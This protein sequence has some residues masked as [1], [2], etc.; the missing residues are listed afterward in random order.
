MFARIFHKTAD[1]SNRCKPNLGAHCPK[2]DRKTDHE[3]DCLQTTKFVMLSDQIYEG[4]LPS[5]CD[6][7]AIPPLPSPR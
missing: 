3:L 7:F 6:H 1:I 2:M 5:S 4:Q